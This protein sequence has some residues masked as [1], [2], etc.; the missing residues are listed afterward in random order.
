[1][2]TG[3]FYCSKVLTA[4][5]SKLNDKAEINQSYVCIL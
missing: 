4:D 3:H 5:K 2:V 1:M